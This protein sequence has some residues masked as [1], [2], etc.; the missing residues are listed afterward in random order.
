MELQFI[1]VLT[2]HQQTS[3]NVSTLFHAYIHVSIDI[4]F[5]A[6]IRS[7]FLSCVLIYF[8]LCA[9]HKYIFCEIFSSVTLFNILTCDS[10]SCLVLQCGDGL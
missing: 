7:C 10:N 3:V 4:N 8:L 5:V 1:C 2:S 9:K 6:K